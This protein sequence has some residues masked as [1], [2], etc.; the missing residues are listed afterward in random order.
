VKIRPS[1]PFNLAIVVFHY[2]LNYSALTRR[3][4]TIQGATS[5]THPTL[6]PKKAKH[7]LRDP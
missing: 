4:R 1:R 7:V 2:R 3:T 6:A 5:G